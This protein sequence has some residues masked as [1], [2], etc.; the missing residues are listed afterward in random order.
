MLAFDNKHLQQRLKTMNET[1]KM[2]T[3][4][5][6]QLQ[7]EKEMHRWSSLVDANQSVKD[8]ITGY[9]VEIEKLRGKLLELET[10]YQSAKRSSTAKEH[11]G[12]LSATALRTGANTKELIELA[13]CSLNKQRERERDTTS[14]CLDS[15]SKD[16]SSDLSEESENEWEIQSKKQ[17]LWLSLHFL[18]L[19]VPII[20]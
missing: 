12:R 13:K 7:V 11:H 8:M 6:T 20:N 18:L 1:V 15:C 4:R 2:L 16:N 9:I 19:F 10:M 14:K 5:N 3:E 17:S